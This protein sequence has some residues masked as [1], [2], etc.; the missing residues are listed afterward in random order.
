LKTSTHGWERAL[1]GRRHSQRSQ[2][3]RGSG[4]KSRQKGK[5]GRARW[6]KKGRKAEFWGG[7][8]EERSAWQKRDLGGGGNYISATVGKGLWEKKEGG[9]A[10]ENNANTC[11]TEK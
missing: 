10:V 4:E 11:P 7:R 6:G 5:F 3:S 9:R 8:R 1:K 2:R